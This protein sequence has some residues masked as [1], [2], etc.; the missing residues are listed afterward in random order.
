MIDLKSTRVRMPHRPD[1]HFLK[2]DA[3]A[4]THWHLHRQASTAWTL[5][6]DLR[7]AVESF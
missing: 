5:E 2:P 3:I 4:D 6:L 7:P 1:H